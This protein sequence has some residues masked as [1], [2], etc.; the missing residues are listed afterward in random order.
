MDFNNRDNGTGVSLVR[1]LVD[2]IGLKTRDMAGGSD[3]GRAIV[4]M[5][6]ASDVQ[7]A[8]VDSTMQVLH[9]ALENI[10]RD[11]KMGELTAAQMDA[12]T[13]AGVIASNFREFQRMEFRSGI[14]AN[15]NMKNVISV[16][17]FGVPDV[18]ERRSYANESYDESDNRSAVAYSITYNLQS[19]RQDD[20][21][22]TIFPT[23][24][25]PA[26]QAGVTIT[27]NLLYVLDNVD[28]NVSGAAYDLK[29]KN[30][31]RAV[32]DPTV[33]K[34]EQT[35]ALP[36]WRN[37]TS[38]DKFVAAGTLPVRNVDIDGEIIPTSAL[39]FGTEVDLLGI[40][41]SDALVALGTQN[42]TDSLDPTVEVTQFFATIAA[43]Q[44]VFKTKDLPYAN[45]VPSAQ[46]DYKTMVLNFESNSILLNK[47]TKRSS[48]ADLTG[49][50]AQ[51]AADD[52][53]V[54]MRV[55]LNG[56]VRLDTG[57]LVVY[58][59]TFAVDRI[60]NADGESV[61][62]DDV[63]VT[64]LVAA[65]NGRTMLGYD[66]L[67]YR[68]NANRR[69]QGQF[70]DVAKQYQRYLVPLRSPITARHPAHINNQID[71]S[72]VQALITTTR[73]RVSN[74]A[75]TSVLQAVDLLASFVDARDNVNESPDVLGVGR[76]YV[77][78]S[79]IT[80]QF[81]AAVKVDSIK[82]H[83][84]ALDIQAALVNEI[85]DVAYL[86]YRD[87]EYKAAADALYGGVGPIPTVIIAT[88]P[89]TA[90]YISIPGDLRTMGGEFNF[91]VVS[92]LDIRFRGKIVITFGI[93]DQERN[94]SIN[95]LNS[96]NLL[97]AP[98]LVLTANIGR[99]G[100]FSRE[101]LVQP[102]YR[103]ITN[104]PVMGVIE[105]S[106]IPNVLNKLPLFM[107]DQTP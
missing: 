94:S 104:L 29:R 105:V 90:R 7:K 71:A 102:R 50:L 17:A 41:Q 9:V 8:A 72:D 31:L 45:F 30:V 107:V 42:Q 85:R 95:P 26:D 86:L 82:S 87:S 106:N 36:V 61:P 70:V 44:L 60:I 84:R 55:V 69:Q 103:F 2:H 5:E 23:I 28:R 21:G 96:G 34:K 12:G 4:A 59:N 67:A 51:I 20:F 101:T 32:A 99:G 35:R 38:S 80:R 81:D 83:E 57:N 54:R 75:V 40:S 98:E 33:L 46:N 14:P 18:L 52:L 88:D 1:D 93:F 19:A 74:E 92:T 89:Y 27:A 66:I 16:E 47:D 68:S 3:A 62:L 13:Q 25:I 79:F 48:G 76:Y 97:W 37:G 65:L 58:G 91:H 49:A 10:A 64:A 43:Q 63:S 73:I 53:I 100:Q 78:T 15:A 6:S 22:E 24:T 56:R 11:M 39:L 77:R